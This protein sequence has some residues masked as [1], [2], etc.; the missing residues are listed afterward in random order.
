MFQSADPFYFG[1]R[2]EP[3]ETAIRRLQ[4]EINEA[5]WRGEEVAALKAQLEELLRKKARGFR[6]HVNF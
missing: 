5:D 6:W 2:A 1:E 3:I 4:H